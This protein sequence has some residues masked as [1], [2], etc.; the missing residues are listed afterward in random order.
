MKRIL[1]SGLALLF[2]TGVMA[3]ADHYLRRHGGHVQHLKITQRGGDT[4]VSMDVDFE[5]NAGD[6]AGARACSAEMGGEAKSPA[7][8]ELVVKRHLESEAKYCV[9][10]IH[11]SGD[12]AKVEQSEGCAYY[13]G[14]FCKF[15][16]EGQAMKKAQ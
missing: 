15:D 16:T 11:L 7:P 9:L 5:P 4:L 14:H 6:K 1:L 10:K 13:A 2:S 8:N 3:G 12:E